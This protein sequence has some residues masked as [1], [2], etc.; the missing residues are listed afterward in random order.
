MFRWRG[1]CRITLCDDC[2]QGIRAQSVTLCV[3]LIMQGAE[4]RPPLVMPGCVVGDVRRKDLWYGP[5]SPGGLQEKWCVWGAWG[6]RTSA[7]TGAVW[8]SCVLPLL[9]DAQRLSVSAVFQQNQNLCEE[10]WKMKFP[11]TFALIRVFSNGYTGETFVAVWPVETYKNLNQ[12]TVS[13][14]AVPH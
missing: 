10:A 7:L 6:W 5:V 4:D 13:K 12:C 3:V 8:L 1:G 11:R 14:D 9:L 2:A